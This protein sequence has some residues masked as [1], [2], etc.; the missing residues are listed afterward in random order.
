MTH[1]KPEAHDAKGGPGPGSEAVVGSRRPDLIQLFER[2]GILLVWAAVAIGFSIAEPNTYLTV[3]NLANIFGSQAV[4]VVVTLALIIP[5]TAGDYDLSVGG[6]VAVSSMTIAVLNGQHGWPIVPAVVAA[7]LAGVVVGLF[8]GLV[9]T[10]FAIDSLIVTLGSQTVLSGLVLWMSDSQTV[11]GVSNSL[12]N[13]VVVQKL[14]GIPLAFYY[15]IVITAAI[16]YLFEQTIFGR[17]L[18]F[19]G[20]GRDV[21]RLSGVRVNR[22]R[23]AALVCSGVVSAIAGVLYV[24]T[25][26]AA[27]P[28][29]GFSFLLPAF[30]AAFLG[31]TA[32]RPGRFNAWGT[33]V[34][35][36][37]L[38]SGI[39]GLELKGVPPFVQQFFYGGALIL[40]VVLRQV[41]R[42]RT[43]TSAE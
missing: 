20:R 26:G 15:A 28:S 6:V 38:I 8:N 39:T 13:L 37:F 41:V 7:I 10:I 42:G 19:T 22:L 35:V 18:L 2:F 43:E 23:V 31:F 25:T 16:W 33:F 9:I 30:A 12:V 29:S 17:K 11:S 3:G 36:Y 24:G 5:L 4:L 32:I 14:F 40:A 1:A 34:A 27:D 21:A